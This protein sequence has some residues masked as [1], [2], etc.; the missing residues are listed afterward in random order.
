MAWVSRGPSDDPVRLLGRI[1]GAL[2]LVD[3]LPPRERTALVRGRHSAGSMRATLTAAA[4]ALPGATVVLDDVPSGSGGR[5]LAAL[6]AVLAQVPNLRLVACARVATG[7]ALGPFL[8]GFRTDGGLTE[9]GP[10]ELAFTPEEAADL[11]RLNGVGLSTP[12]HESLVE[13]TGGW[14]AALCLAVR[15]IGTAADPAAAAARFD[16]DGDAAVEFFRYEVMPRLEPADR[17]LLLRTSFAET[18]SAELADALTGAAEPDRPRPHGG[19]A[20]D[21]LRATGLVTPVAGAPRPAYRVH[22]FFRSYLRHEAALGLAGRSGAA[23]ERPGVGAE[24]GTDLRPGGGGAALPADTADRTGDRRGAVRL[25]EHGQD[26]AQE[27]LPQARRAE[28][29]GRRRPGPS[30]GSA[31]TATNP[32]ADPMAVLRTPGYLRLLVLAALLGLPISAASYGFL[33]LVQSGQEFVYDDLPGVIGFD[34]PPAWW[35]LPVLALAGVLVAATIRYLPGGGGHV[36]A[37]GLA[38]GGKPT[39]PIELPGVVLAALASLVLGVVLGPE[40]P[41]IAMG[42]GLALLTLRLLRRDVPAASA[43]VVAATG[44][45]AAISTLLGSPLVGAFL[46]MEASGLGGAMMGVVL[47]PGLLAA[48]TGALI[49]IGLGD[50]TGLGTLSLAVP[51]LPAVGQPTLAQF[52]WALVVGVAAA[53]AGTAIRRGGLAL[54]PLVRRH[55]MPLTVLAGLAV[56]ALVM[57]F[58]LVTGEAESLVLFSGQDALSPL[59]TTSPEFSPG[60]SASCSSASP[61]RTP[62]AWPASAA[63]RC[64]RRSSSVRPAGWRCPTCPACRWLPGRRWA[65][66]RCRW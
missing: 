57:V 15:T 20:L 30:D 61:S 53:L 48:G 31:V 60:R 41:L 10:T 49:F 9:I 5:G 6:S 25:S 11:L 40:A 3:A 65:S 21:R 7:P 27:P 32:P 50:W 46:L 35:P 26:P 34:S 59:L 36:P 62:S 45:F 14:A 2:G 24:A 39:Q 19:A 8:A 58:H 64:S 37:H 55:R 4:L 47:L 56:G 54:E 23:P 22:R 66:G 33:A 63:V 44:S 38:V 18:V 43:S 1:A 13:R 17:D 29:A 51:D 12:V 52:G 28:P 16:G 42:G